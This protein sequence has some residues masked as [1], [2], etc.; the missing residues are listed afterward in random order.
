M[1]KKRSFISRCCLFAISA[2]L[3]LAQLHAAQAFSPPRKKLI[4]AGW[5]R[6]NASQ[7][8]QNQQEAEQSPYDGTVLSLVGEDDGGKTVNLKDLV[9]APKPLQKKWFAKEI[10]A[11]KSFHST[12]LTD[13][14]AAI[15]VRGN[16][17]DWFDDKGWKVIADNWK[18]AAAIAKEGNLKGLCFDPE[19]YSGAKLW[20]YAAQQDTRKHSYAEYSA[21]VR[22]RG[23]EIIRAVSSVY[24]GMVF[25]T[26]RMNDINKA[27]TDGGI[28]SSN[29]GLYPAFINGWLDGASP[30]M[31]F[32]DGGEP[33]PTAFPNSFCGRPTGFATPG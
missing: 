19:M 21:K 24:P 31:T 3:I 22:Q 14:F 7:L 4:E 32:V 12:K 2:G 30:L 20:T 29:Y 17:P 23:R 1:V 8:L 5:D 10:N 9:F 28:E 26:F 15:T 6:M 33:I 11:L 27:Y 13:N 25:F 18:I 16:P